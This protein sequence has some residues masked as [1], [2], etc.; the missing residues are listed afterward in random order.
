[1]LVA[2][3]G[4]GLFVA[5]LVF[6]G[7]SRQFTYSEF[8]DKVAAGQVS[9]VTIHAKGRVEGRLKDQT[10]FTTVIP[11]P[12]PQQ[13]LATQLRDQAVV[14]K[15]VPENGGLWGAAAGLLPLLLLVGLAWYLMRRS[16]GQWSSLGGI[17]RSRAKVIDTERPDTRFEDVAGYESVKQEIC[18]V[19][20][21]L[22]DPPRY[23][24][25][26]AHGPG[27][28]LLVGPPGTGKTLLARAVAGEAE[29]PFLYATGSGF[30]EML[31]GV[32]ASRVRDLF[33]EARRRAPAIIFIDELDSVG[34]KRGSAA[35]IGSHNEQEQTLNELLAEMDGFDPAEGIVVM[36]ATNR[37]E[38]LDEALLRPGRFDRRISI[39]LPTQRDRRA[40]LEVHV[41][42]K[43]LADDVD[44]DVVARAT[45]GFSG[46]DLANLT[47]EAAIFAVRD[48]RQVI[49]RD[50]FDGARDRIVL[51]QRLDPSILRPEEKRR[52]AVHEAGHALVTVLS[53]R[54][55]PL[56]KV[57]ILPTGQALGTTQQLPFEERR[58]HSESFL[59]DLLSVR[60]GGRTAERLVL[61]EASSGAANDLAEATHIATRMVRDFGLS[62]R[63]GPIGYSANG[64]QEEGVPPALRS[65]PY[66]EA[67]QRLVDEET[68]RLLRE[69][70]QR[71]HELLT[72]H[73]AQLDKLVDLLLEEETVEGE[74]VYELLGRPVP[75][76][77]GSPETATEA[78]GPQGTTSESGPLDR[79]SPDAG[80]RAT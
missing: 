11:T 12:L 74:Q 76:R 41:R 38:M 75:R 18:E 33:E 8:L 58:L 61:G 45:A 30:V 13:E 71:A 56:D 15:A 26:G 21:F 5:I 79:R 72:A 69:A 53:P 34:R 17:G 65:R 32:G 46:A 48:D 68:A 62:E 14:I 50:D 51:G 6:T 29:V 77:A 36:A 39:N 60:L 9:E 7:P 31:V 44:L 63:L 28:L 42:D 4:T 10:T 43:H 59:G 57:T 52:V 66:A 70:E 24:R 25:A 22:K 20:D 23:R 37:P 2:A 19:V 73:R 1:M 47:N 78:G 35:T 54:A 49:T 55:D 80:G 67:T 64:E 27:G 40:I 3:V 16:G